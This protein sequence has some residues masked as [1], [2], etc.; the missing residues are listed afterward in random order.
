MVS[1][2]GTFLETAV[3][4]AGISI[5]LLAA[6]ATL[7]EN[8]VQ[9]LPSAARELMVGTAWTSLLACLC[10]LWRFWVETRKRTLRSLRTP[11]VATFVCIVLLGFTFL[12]F[13]EPSAAN[14]LAGFLRNLADKFSQPQ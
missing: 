11:L 8:T 5:A 2:L 14:M 9:K 13:A 7:P 4:V 12:V 6:L 1:M 10:V 3:T